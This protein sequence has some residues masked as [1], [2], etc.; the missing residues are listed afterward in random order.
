MS[1]IARWQRAMTL[2]SGFR[3]HSEVAGVYLL[4]G[5]SSIIIRLID[6]TPQFITFG[7]FVFGA[8]TVVAYGVLLGKHSWGLGRR[9]KLMVVLGLCFAATSTAFTFAVKY[10]T[11]ANALLITFS[12][13]AAV[14]FLARW[15]LKE[16][17]RPVALAALGLAVAGIVIVVVP[18]LRAIDRRSAIGIG[19]AFLAAS[20]I[21]YNTVGV[22]LIRRVTS[23]FTVGLYR[24]MIPALVLLPITLSTSPLSISGGSLVLL[25]ILGIVQTGFAAIVYAHGMGRVEA[26]DAVVY[27]YLEPI[28]S[29]ILPR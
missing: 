13:P 21:A 19:F 1:V 20:G 27:S 14:P 9:P 5:T 8:A 10:T 3:G 6:Q 12:S 23:A 17:V 7:R 18:D 28:G 16:H 4:W 24:T 29:I 26:Q 22:R 2:P 25:L 15:I 11:V